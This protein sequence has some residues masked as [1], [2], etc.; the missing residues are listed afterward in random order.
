MPHRKSLL[1]P[2]HPSPGNPAWGN[3][4]CCLFRLTG[5]HSIRPHLRARARCIHGPQVGHGQD[6]TAISVSQKSSAHARMTWV[7]G[8]SVH[9]GDGE[10]S[11][12]D[13]PRSSGTD[14]RRHCE[15]RVDRRSERPPLARHIASEENRVCVSGE[16]LSM[17]LPIPCPAASPQTL[18]DWAVADCPIAGDSGLLSAVG[19]LSVVF[20][21]ILPTSGT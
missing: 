18:S 3:L 12:E 10:S 13:G 11:H 15:R 9:P 8:A 14:G 16:L 1:L 21:C 19:G 7:P 17:A 6:M 4:P 2:D 20:E 5:I